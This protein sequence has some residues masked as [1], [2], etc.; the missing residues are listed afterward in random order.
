MFAFTALVLHLAC[1]FTVHRFQVK[2]DAHATQHLMFSVVVNSIALSSQVTYFQ[3]FWWGR[4]KAKQSCL[5][6]RSIN[7]NLKTS[8]S[9]S[10][11]LNNMIEYFYSVHCCSCSCSALSTTSTNDGYPLNILCYAFC[12]TG[13]HS[14]CY[15]TR[16]CEYMQFKNGGSS[17]FF[18]FYA[19]FMLTV[20]HCRQVKSQETSKSF[21][22]WCWC[23]IEM[24][25]DVVG[26]R[27][28]DDD[29]CGRGDLTSKGNNM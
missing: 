24:M 12:S 11:N 20:S 25:H 10:I 14:S 29:V 22:D 2:S 4:H 19:C 6:F 26:C 17:P 3:G 7:H 1:R 16:D 18:W 23:A 27:M 13:V 21:D 8:P 15:P 28:L 9:I 5:A